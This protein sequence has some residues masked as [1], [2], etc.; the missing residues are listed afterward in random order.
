M[1]LIHGRRQIRSSDLRTNARE[2]TA[3][4]LASGRA[5]RWTSSLA[6]TSRLTAW[7]R[8]RLS[9]DDLSYQNNLDYS[10]AGGSSVDR[11]QHLAS[12]RSSPNRS[13]YD[14]AGQGAPAALHVAA[15]HVAVVASSR[16]GLVGAP[17]TKLNAATITT[18]L[19]KERIQALLCALTNQGSH[20]RQPKLTAVNLSLTVRQGVSHWEPP[21]AG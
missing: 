6:A 11:G 2:L 12:L 18:F 9:A 1:Q 8:S 21:S 17:P 10:P 16:H 19:A 7:P 13:K 3:V 4:N 14:A 20:P 5:L 15:G